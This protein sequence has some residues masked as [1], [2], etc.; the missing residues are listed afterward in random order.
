MPYTCFHEPGLPAQ[1]GILLQ[2]LPLVEAVPF[3]RRAAKA[4]TRESALGGTAT[5]TATATV[6]E[7]EAEVKVPTTTNNNNNHSNSKK[8]KYAQT[9]ARDY[10]KYNFPLLLSD[11]W[12][13]AKTYES[14]QD[15][16]IPIR[17]LEAHQ[18]NQDNARK[19]T[20]ASLHWRSTKEI[21]TILARPHVNYDIA[22]RVLPHY[23]I[24]FSAPAGGGP[25]SNHVVFIQRPGLTD[26]DLA[27]HNGISIDDML[28]QYAYVFEY[29]W[30]VLHPSDASIEDSLMI[31]IID[32][33]GLNLGLLRKPALI[34][35][36]K[37]FVGMI[38]AHY[39]TRAHQT[40]MMNAPGWFS[41]LYKLIAPILR[42]TTKEKIT[43]YSAGKAQ[44]EA[45]VEALGNDMGST[46]N[47]A[48]S[49]NAKVHKDA[50]NKFGL[51]PLSSDVL[52][53]TDMERE[54]RDFVRILCSMNEFYSLCFSMYTHTIRFLLGFGLA[55][56]WWDDWN[57]MDLK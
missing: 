13:N 3:F 16:P 39:P 51:S 49:K 46:V 36:V 24:G 15:A 12:T 19:A 50:V 21:D 22:K 2:H 4:G 53:E 38:D 7:V 44:D 33:Q 42:E 47:T 43:L 28:H 1:V 26:L 29:C 52:L 41:T 27:T 35:F 10:Q 18:S 5:A 48:L 40:Y 45:I 25:A 30:N 32:L 56:R 34:H 9:Q 55:V 11:K 14:N 6:Q 20:I 54:M 37:E 8:R 31:S 23:F 57:K 17:Y